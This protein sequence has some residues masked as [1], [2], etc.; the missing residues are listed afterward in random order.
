MSQNMLL[1]NVVLTALLVIWGY[2]ISLFHDRRWVA[3]TTVA[4]VIFAV[5]AAYVG[6]SRETTSTEAQDQR[7]AQIDQ[8]FA[9]VKQQ[10]LLL[11][12][13][14]DDLTSNISAVNAELITVGK[15]LGKVNESVDSGS[16]ALSNELDTSKSS[17]QELQKELGATKNRLQ[18]LQKIL[19]RL[20]DNY[21]TLAKETANSSKTLSTIQARLSEIKEK[22]DCIPGGFSFKG[23]GC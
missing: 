22:T 3:Y 23:F 5:A 21:D 14:L 20:E 12:E 1:I 16:K 18:S 6:Y 2:I 9:S 17:L 10:T 13:K 8:F 11:R 7:A 15:T 19:V 4:V